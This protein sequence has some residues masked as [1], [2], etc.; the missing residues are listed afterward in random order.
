MSI[1]HASLWATRPITQDTDDLTPLTVLPADRTV[2]LVWTDPSTEQTGYNF[3][4]LFDTTRLTEADTEFPAW[5]TSTGRRLRYWTGALPQ[6]RTTTA[7]LFA[8]G[9]DSST[10]RPLA[11]ATLDVGDHPVLA[12]GLTITG[13]LTTA[14]L[15]VQNLSVA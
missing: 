4:L 1:P 12:N 13:R 7:I 6:Q 15:D 8:V 14:R 3:Q 5:Q 11:N 2:S 9:G 10:P